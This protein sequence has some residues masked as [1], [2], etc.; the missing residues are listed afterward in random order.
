MI[1]EIVEAEK[2][3]LDNILFFFSRSLVHRQR[4]PAANLNTNNKETRNV[5]IN[6]QTA[7]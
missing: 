5:M 3:G 7:E 2:E 1:I 6:K 4:K